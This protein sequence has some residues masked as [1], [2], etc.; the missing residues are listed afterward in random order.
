MALLDY[1]ELSAPS[2][3]V[4]HRSIFIMNDAIHMVSN[5]YLYRY[6][7]SN[8]SSSQVT[9][10]FNDG[11]DASYLAWGGYR[12]VWCSGNTLYMLL[13]KN[14]SP[15][16]NLYIYIKN[17]STGVEFGPSP[18][19]KKT[20]DQSTMEVTYSGWWVSPRHV[21]VESNDFIVLFDVPGSPYTCAF[22]DVEV[23]NEIVTHL[24]VQGIV[25]N[26]T[27]STNFSSSTG[28]NFSGMYIYNNTVYT[29]YEGSILASFDVSSGTFTTVDSE[30][31]HVYLLALATNGLVYEKR[32]DQQGDFTVDDRV[33]I[34]LYDGSITDV[35]NGKGF[36]GYSS[37]PIIYDG[38]LY[39]HGGNKTQGSSYEN[40]FFKVTLNRDTI[41]K[42][43][44]L[45]RIVNINGYSSGIYPFEHLGHKYWL[46][47]CQNGDANQS[48]LVIKHNGTIHYISK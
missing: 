15:I 47:E 42:L 39:V 2:G 5:G 23:T 10:V 1:Q 44:H 46:K 25:A 11:S 4:Q 29:R 19:Y 18:V 9:T 26:I 43:G 45:N 21:A 13:R 3:V 30:F 20:I 40:N 32:S 35:G 36:F 34:R 48:P 38:D 37:A 14:G 8:D 22:G 33:D 17:I 7:A 31:S 27:F 16:A 41:L 28:G 6:D 24:G 12:Y